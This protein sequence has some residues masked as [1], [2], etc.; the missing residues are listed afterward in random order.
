VRLLALRFERG[1]KERRKE[2]RKMYH[3]EWEDEEEAEHGREGE[4]MH[5]VVVEEDGGL[6]IGDGVV[7]DLGLMYGGAVKTLL[8]LWREDELNHLFGAY[9][10]MVAE[11]GLC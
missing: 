3:G 9:E 5:V 1:E 4:T 8:K 10:E 6:S 2:G 7:K 11:S